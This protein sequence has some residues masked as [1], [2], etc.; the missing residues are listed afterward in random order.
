MATL[1]QFRTRYRYIATE[2]GTT[3]A[4]HTSQ[5]SQDVKPDSVASG[6]WITFPDGSKFRKPTNYSRK[7][8]GI[9]G[10]SP[11]IDTGYHRQTAGSKKNM[12][13]VS[14]SNGGWHDEALLSQNCPDLGGLSFNK[15]IDNYKFPSGMENEAITNALNDIASQKAN[16]GETLGTMRQTVQMIRSPAGSLV[17]LLTSAWK[18]RSL[19]PYL[20]RSVRDIRRHGIPETV[21]SRYLEY[22][23]GWVPLVNDIYGIME[24]MK[25]KS[26]RPLLLTGRGKSNRSQQTGSGRFNDFSNKSFCSIGPLNEDVKVRCQLHGRIDPNATALRTLNQL[27]LL[28]PASLAWDLTPWSFVVDWFVPIGPVL[29]ALTAPAGLH[30]VAGSC[31]VR[32]SV[33]GP[34]QNAYTGARGAGPTGNVSVSTQNATGTAWRE[35]YSRK[36]YDKWPLPSFY[37]SNDPFKGDRSLKALAL[38]IVNLRK[39]RV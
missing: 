26:S 30:F 21:A 5:T 28:N 3:T 23:Y 29:S 16:I 35:S 9:R 13:N 36:T 17:N 34:Y 22:I 12:R 27:G 18:D 32:A 15:L 2:N 10:D 24:L 14:T 1:Y 31:S 20:K 4:S 19:R 37:F 11:Q 25:D 39:L 7:S 6:S 8:L 38:S 33:S